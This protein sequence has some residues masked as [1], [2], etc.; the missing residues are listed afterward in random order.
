MTDGSGRTV[1]SWE[2]D[3]SVALEKP[4]YKAIKNGEKTIH[5]DKELHGLEEGEDGERLVRWMNGYNY[6]N[7]YVITTV[8]EII[9]VPLEQLTD[10]ELEKANVDM[11]W[12]ENYADNQDE[13]Y[14]FFLGDVLIVGY[15][16]GYEGLR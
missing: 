12:V 1:G 15:E 14:L 5:I 16:E 8:P 13:V 10:G 4:Y 6:K 9:S 3:T 7:G 2:V 11:D